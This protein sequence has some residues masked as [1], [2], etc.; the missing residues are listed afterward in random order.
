MYFKV[1]SVKKKYI[2]ILLISPESDMII[3]FKKTQIF[4]IKFTSRFRIK[5]F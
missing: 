5:L 1:L 3:V 4:F 2:D